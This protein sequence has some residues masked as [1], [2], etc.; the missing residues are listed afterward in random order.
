MTE[1]PYNDP[2]YFA[3]PRGVPMSAVSQAEQHIAQEFGIRGTPEVVR[4]E[5]AFTLCRLSNVRP[6]SA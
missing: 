2:F 4:S 6:V 1:Q 5:L 3:I